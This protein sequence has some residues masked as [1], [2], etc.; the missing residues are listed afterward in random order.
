ML[1]SAESEQ[2]SLTLKLFLKIFNLITIPQ[3]HGRTDRQTEERLAVAIPRSRGNKNCSCRR[4]PRVA[5]RNDSMH[6]STE[7]YNAETWTQYNAYTR[8]P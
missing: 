5:T 2:P 3:R 7:K 6:I 4:E 1:G 8:H